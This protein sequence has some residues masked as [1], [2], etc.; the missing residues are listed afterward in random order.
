M[1][2]VNKDKLEIT[3]INTGTMKSYISASGVSDKMYT[4]VNKE[5]AIVRFINY[6]ELQ[7]AIVY[8]AGKHTK[9]LK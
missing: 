1:Y 4:V 8:L 5:K 3:F 6:A 7:K 9:W 2:K